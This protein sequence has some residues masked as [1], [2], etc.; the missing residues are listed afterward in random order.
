MIKM[1][2]IK[3]TVRLELV[4]LNIFFMKLTLHKCVFWGI[5]IIILFFPAFSKTQQL[6]L[7]DGALCQKLKLLTLENKRLAQENKM[8][9]TDPVYI[10]EIAR[11]KLRVARENEIV[12][13]VIN[14][15][16][17]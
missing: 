8:L 17:E 1:P 4:L 2:I 7:K 9:K 13:R 15:N 12:F 11:E 3:I 16:K 14:D 6:R 5:L 10:E